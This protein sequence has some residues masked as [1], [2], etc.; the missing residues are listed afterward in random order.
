MVINQVYDPTLTSEKSPNAIR[1]NVETSL[2]HVRAERVLVA[3]ET[4][5]DFCVFDLD[6]VR[7]LLA[8][9]I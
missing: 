2:S 3:S 1:I 6:D 9:A 8:A 5:A 7:R 4:F